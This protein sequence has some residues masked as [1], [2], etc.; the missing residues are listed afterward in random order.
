M[1]PVNDHV[2]WEQ[3]ESGLDELHRKFIS[4]GVL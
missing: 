3:A 1:L 2:Y 4:D